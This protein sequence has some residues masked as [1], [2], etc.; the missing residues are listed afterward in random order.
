MSWFVFLSTSIKAAEIHTLPQLCVLYSS[1]DVEGGGF[2]VFP[3]WPL[4]RLEVAQAVTGA[5][6]LGSPSL[7]AASTTT[8]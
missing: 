2:P 7:A 6:I 1:K 4:G 8:Y 3:A 5:Q